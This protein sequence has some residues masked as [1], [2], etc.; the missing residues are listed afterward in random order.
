MGAGMD[1][2]P[3]KQE[4]EQLIPEKVDHIKTLASVNRAAALGLAVCLSLSIAL[5]GCNTS[6][7]E[8]EKEEEEDESYYTSSS[9]GTHGGGYF[10]HRGGTFLGGSWRSSQ[11]LAR[12]GGY[13]TVRG[14]SY[15]G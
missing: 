12:S 8:K 6:K 2:T 11:T 10:Y 1:K 13:S 5:T 9:G 15:G 7:E 14:G 3:D 4:T